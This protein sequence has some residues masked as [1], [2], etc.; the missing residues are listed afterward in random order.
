MSD[1]CDPHGL[2]PTRHLCPWDFLG[3]NTGVACQFLPQS[4]FLT[5]GS[6]PHLL[7]C[8]QILYCW[9][10]WEVLCH[11]WFTP[12]H[13]EPVSVSR[14]FFRCWLLFSLSMSN[15]LLPQGLQ[16]ARLPC[17]SPSPG[18]CSNSCPLK[19]W[20]HP[21]I[22][23][24]AIPFSSCLQSFLASGSFPMSL[25]FASGGNSIGASASASVL[26]MNVQGWFPFGLTALISLQSK[27]LSSLFQHHSWS[28]ST[29]LRCWI[30]VLFN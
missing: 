14:C 21:T 22:S 4:I 27:G 30:L 7:H 6:N 28:A 9:A 10:T 8:R 29:T 12:T 16:H 2:W 15:S 1:S 5:Q 23:S 11:G 26:P 20:C 13:Q 18:V 25:F 3:K 24:S 19:W 17:P